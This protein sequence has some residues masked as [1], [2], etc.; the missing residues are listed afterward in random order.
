V[1]HLAHADAAADDIGMS[2]FDVGDDQRP[3]GRGMCC[4]NGN[5]D[6]K[7]LADLSKC[8]SSR[9]ALDPRRSS[10]YD[11]AGPARDPG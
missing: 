1:P 3:C 10:S 9:I 5:R 11:G 4:G 2:R 8:V 7:N 6:K